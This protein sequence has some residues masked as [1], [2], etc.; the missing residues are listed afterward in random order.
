MNRFIFFIVSISSFS[1]AIAERRPKAEK[2]KLQIDFQSGF[3]GDDVIIQINDIQKFQARNVTTERSTGF[4][5]S[6]SYEVEPGLLRIT[7]LADS[8]IIFGH[9]F[10]F[11]K[12]IFMGIRKRKKNKAHVIFSDEAFQYR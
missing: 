7:I 12:S 10:E 3:D 11:R 1:F 4:A 2:L 9:T 6:F 8:K 5:E